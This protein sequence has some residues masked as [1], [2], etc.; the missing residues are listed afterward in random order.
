MF[1]SNYSKMKNVLDQ[2]ERVSMNYL[3]YRIFAEESKDT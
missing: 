1:E 2:F 3:Y